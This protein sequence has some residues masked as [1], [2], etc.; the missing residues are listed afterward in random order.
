MQT[1]QG[2]NIWWWATGLLV[3]ALVLFV[4]A[5]ILHLG[6]LE[7]FAEAAL[8]GGLADWF[9]VVALFRKPLNLPIP[10]TAVIPNNKDRIAE[11]L[12]G[13]VAENFLTRKVVESKIANLDL[14]G[15]AG[16]WVEE[17][18][19]SLT[20][21]IVSEVPGI[22]AGLDEGAIQKIIQREL[23]AGVEKLDFAKSAAGLLESLTAQGKHREILSK[24]LVGAQALIEKNRES[25]AEEIRQELPL[26]ELEGIPFLGDT[27]VASVRRAA[28]DAVASLLVYKIQKVLDRAKADDNHKLRSEFDEALAGLVRNLRESQEYHQKAQEMKTALLESK[29]VGDYISSIWGDLKKKILDDLASTD[30]G[31]RRAL[32]AAVKKIGTTL[33]QEQVLKDR[34]N[35]WLKPE[36]AE[37]AEKNR[38][39][40]ARMIEETV[41]QWDGRDLAEK[42]E[43][44]TG[45]D[46]QFIR[47]NGTLVGGLAGLLIYL[48]SLW[49]H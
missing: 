21:K 38:H 17:N 8:V 13:F 39:E 32:L 48:G 27:I 35:A 19:E 20:Q 37:L 30:S 26:S 45:R 24:I 15:R 10:H 49:L 42:L 43:E 33:Q 14:T 29:E 1:K 36:L 47:L 28:G 9:A 12:G 44:H 4:V 46:L 3:V 34:I 16:R 22:L 23:R 7:A 5:K 25:I 6:W 41:K 2:Q 11:S 31:I 40:V 18:A